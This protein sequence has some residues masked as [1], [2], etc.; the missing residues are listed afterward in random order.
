MKFNSL[1]ARLI[2]T[3]LWMAI[4][5]AIAVSWMAANLMSE[6][7]MSER[8]AGVGHIAGA[9]HDQLVMVLTRANNRA[10]HFLSDL[11]NQC[12]GNA[13]RLNHVC[14]TSLIKAYLAAE[15][16]IG[17]NIHP[18]GNG[19]SLTV[20][21]SAVRDKE[22]IALQPGQLAKFSS[23]GP[24][25]DHSYFVSVTEKSTGLH[26]SITYPSSVLEP[27]FNPPPADLGLS[28]ET[29]LADGEG[30]FVTQP[31]YASTQGH[32]HPISANP[33]QACLNKQ[34]GEALDLDYR[35]TAII[36]GFHFVPEFG[37][38]CIMAHV[39]QDEAFAPLRL[40]ER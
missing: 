8:I 32:S 24:K 9:K 22:C 40:L 31:K 37:S 27:V 2:I 4:A 30:H 28:G 36:H 5:P 14:A 11:S 17:A 38:A 6:H 3:L 39:A 10:E 21:A 35:D 18:E 12:G 16:A 20:G 1:K 15:G 29:F 33:M 25:S 7:I 13:A 34:S 19:D 23:T 26:L